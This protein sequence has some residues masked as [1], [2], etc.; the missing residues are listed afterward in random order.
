MGARYAMDRRIIG[1]P[2]K[3]EAHYA[4]LSRDRALTDEE[5]ER[6]AWAIY[7][8]RLGAQERSRQH[9]LAKARAEELALAEKVQAELDTPSLLKEDEF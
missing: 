8:Q 7:K 6:L 9:L 3:I 5:S 1:S 2:E 4:R